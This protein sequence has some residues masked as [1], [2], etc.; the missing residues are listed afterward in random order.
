MNLFDHEKE[1]ENY[2]LTL[3]S[4]KKSILRF[5]N[6]DWM[7]RE[8]ACILT[9]FFSSFWLLQGCHEIVATKFHD[10]SINSI[11]SMTFP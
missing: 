1:K 8:E 6:V 11:N 4:S 10:F 7:C 9:H 3:R 2:F 5:L